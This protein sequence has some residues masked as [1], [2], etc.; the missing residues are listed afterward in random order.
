MRRAIL[1]GASM[2]LRE[3][4]ALEARC[5]GEV[6]AT[7]DMRIGV[8]NFLTNGPRSKADFVHA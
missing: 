4:I 1:E 8:G 2:N 5:F 7:K 6:C 3:G